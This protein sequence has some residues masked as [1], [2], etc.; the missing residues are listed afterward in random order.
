MDQPSGSCEFL[1]RVTARVQISSLSGSAGLLKPFLFCNFPSMVT[2]KPRCTHAFV[3]IESELDMC[4]NIEIIFLMAFESMKS[5][6]EGIMMIKV[7]PI[8]VFYP[9]YWEDAG[10]L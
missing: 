5:T 8:G 7:G 6:R 10:L 9:L 4:C 2:G 1:S 3:V